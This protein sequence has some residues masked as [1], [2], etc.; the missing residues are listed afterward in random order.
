MQRQQGLGCILLKPGAIEG[1]VANLLALGI[2][3]EGAHRWRGH[4]WPGRGPDHG[5]SDGGYTCGREGGRGGRGTRAGREMGRKVTLPHTRAS[6]N[7]KSSLPNADVL[8]M[9]FK[10]NFNF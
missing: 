5:W 4:I 8:Q 2:E 3:Q 9:F 1:Q 7:I 6:K 10:R